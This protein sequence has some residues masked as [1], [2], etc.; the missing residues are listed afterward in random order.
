MSEASVK[1]QVTYID[2]IQFLEFVIF[3][4]I[5]KHGALPAKHET[6]WE[7]TKQNR[8]GEVHDCFPVNCESLSSK[9]ELKASQ[10]LR[11]EMHGRNRCLRHLRYWRS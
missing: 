10:E 3:S 11:L 2:S 8:L 5:G 6:I 1:E 4:A 9:V 7:E